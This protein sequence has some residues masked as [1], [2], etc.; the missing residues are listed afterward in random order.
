MGSGSGRVVQEVLA[1]NAVVVE[2]EVNQ[3]SIPRIRSFGIQ[4]CS[5]IGSPGLMPTRGL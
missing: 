5:M 2:P 1:P 4:T 3:L